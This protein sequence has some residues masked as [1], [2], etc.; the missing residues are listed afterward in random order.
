MLI[1]L[2][3]KDTFR[4][5]QR[6]KQMKKKFQADRD[7]QGLNTLEID[8][9]KTDPA[10]ITNIMLSAPFLAEK[11]M[12]ILQNFLTSKHKKLQENILQ[13]I[14][15]KTLPEDTIYIFFESTDTFRN[16][17][18]KS[19]FSRLS[20][21]KFSQKFDLL[22]GSQLQAYIAEE[23]Q[24]KNMDIE[25]KALIHFSQN[26]PVDMWKTSQIIEQVINTAQGDSIKLEDVEYFLPKK[27]DD[28]IF[29]LIDFIAQ[30]KHKHVFSMIRKQTETNDA[31]YVFAMILRQM[32]ILLNLKDA[33]TRGEN[34]RNPLLAK[35]MKLHPYVIKKSIPLLQ[36]YSLNQLKNI[37]LQL[38]EIDKAIK[39]GTKADVL[40]D[41]LV[42]KLALQ[43]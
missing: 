33:E 31:H 20:T 5:R 4:S 12:V 21:E 17:L 3:G 18:N 29:N 24:K 7:P 19:I 8:C 28:N 38:L 9:T 16:K 26:A 40:V 15:E 25:Q 37:H 6:L 34:I 11:R 41:I 42:G 36:S 43:K 27:I 22:S 23:I 30:K 35:K 39:L 1:F 14:E 2:Y 13:R 10:E 32:K